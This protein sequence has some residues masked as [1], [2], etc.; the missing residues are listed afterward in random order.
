[1][2]NTTTTCAKYGK[3]AI[4]CYLDQA[5][6]SP[7][8]HDVAT[9]EEAMRLGYEPN[10]ETR[11]AMALIDADKDDLSEG[12][13]EERADALEFISEM[14]DEAIDWLN[15]QEAR[16]FLFWGN[17]GEVGAFGL[18]PNVEGAREDC[19]F[20]SSKTQDEPDADFVG[21]WLS[22]ND[23]GNV[24]LYVRHEGGKDE[25]VWSVV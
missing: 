1:M 14:A 10:A 23:H 21:D 12:E 24:T 2:K 25:E 3:P 11:D 17:N 18:W 20:L 7:A 6:R 4:G 15:E 8:E 13:I 9:I 19:G 16:P 22:V 5:N